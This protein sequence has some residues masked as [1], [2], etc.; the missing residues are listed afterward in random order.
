[1]CMCLFVFVCN[2][3]PKGEKNSPKWGKK[4]PKLPKI[5]SQGTPNT[6][7]LTPRGGESGRRLTRRV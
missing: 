7:K 6:P 4:F 3:N 5:P 2:K 1:M